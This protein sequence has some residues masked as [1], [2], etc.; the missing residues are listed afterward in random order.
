MD[1]LLRQVYNEHL[2]VEGIGSVIKKRGIFCDKVFSRYK[3]K[4]RH[5]N[6][7]ELMGKDDLSKMV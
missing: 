2:S 6:R 3:T 4:R 5:I 1:V 7:T